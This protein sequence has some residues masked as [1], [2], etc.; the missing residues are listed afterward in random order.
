MFI[1]DSVGRDRFSLMWSR[2]IVSYIITYIYA[3]MYH[4]YRADPF[5][6]PSTLLWRGGGRV[7]SRENLSPHRMKTAQKNNGFVVV[8]AV[9][10]PNKT[11][12]KSDWAS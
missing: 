9:P 6:R 8:S 3:D 2:F 1:T 4:G 12:G 10:A 5:T 11:I 7:H